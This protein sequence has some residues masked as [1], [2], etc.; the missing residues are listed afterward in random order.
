MGDIVLT[1][2]PTLSV[3]IP[4]HQQYTYLSLLLPN[5][6]RAVIFARGERDD[7]DDE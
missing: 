7:D 3:G 1:S 6:R 4:A 2:L 5:D